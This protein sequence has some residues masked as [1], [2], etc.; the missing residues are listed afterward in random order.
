M[1]KH[2]KK[3]KNKL[4]R[5]PK[6]IKSAISP[7]LQEKT[8]L[9]QKFERKKRFFSSLKKIGPWILAFLT[10]LGALSIYS[11]YP[12]VLI[13]ETTLLKPSNPFYYPFIIY[14]AGNIPV[15]DFSY[16]LKVG[17]M[18][19]S[20]SDAMKNNIFE[21]TNSIQKIKIGGRNPVD[22]STFVN[23][24]RLDIK[25]CTI[26][27]RYKYYIPIIKIPFS[28]STKFVLFKDAF[29]EYKWKEYQY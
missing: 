8:V 28:D 21:R 26:F 14:N 18:D 9:T 22:L 23:I 27:I 20:N 16:N 17:V 6:T 12:R 25:S 19:L 3:S 1:S 15:N 4:K 29:N 5:T 13:Q 10:L 24:E 2:K 7:R 11:F